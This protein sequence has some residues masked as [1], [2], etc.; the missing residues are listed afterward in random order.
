MN[1]I[2]YDVEEMRRRHLTIVMNQ[3]EDVW[4]LPRLTKGTRCPFWRSEE[5]QCEK[6]L[7]PRAT[8]YNTGWIGGYHNPISTKI[9]FPPTERKVV[10]YEEGVRKEYDVRPWTLYT[11]RLVER[12]L[13]V[14]VHSG[15][16]Y[17]I[18][19]VMEIRWRG[20]V[21]SQEFELIELTRGASTS[22]AYAVPVPAP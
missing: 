7:D 1:E 18:T 22:Y 10:D 6:P 4:V 15:V 2:Q 5:E 9:V 12:M 14:R 8:C 20:L 3:G 17:M 16:R 13:M 21:M 11:P 19:N